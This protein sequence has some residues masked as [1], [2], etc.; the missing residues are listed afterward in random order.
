MVT[1]MVRAAI[2]VE[3][4]TEA[5]EVDTTRAVATATEVDILINNVPLDSLL[6]RTMVRWIPSSLQLIKF[7]QLMGILSRVQL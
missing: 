1:P 4:T 2:E 5:V 6:D 3:A 7:H